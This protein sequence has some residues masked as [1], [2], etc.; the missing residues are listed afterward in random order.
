MLLADCNHHQHY[1]LEGNRPL[2]LLSSTLSLQ[3]AHVAL[4]TAVADPCT[5]L[6]LLQYLVWG[7]KDWQKEMGNKDTTVTLK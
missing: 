1:R 4:K 3:M 2:S 6:L 7:Y 5:Q